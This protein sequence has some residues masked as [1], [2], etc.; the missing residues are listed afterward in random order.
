[1]KKIAIIMIALVALSSFAVRDCVEVRAAARTHKVVQTAKKRAKTRKRINKKLVRK[2]LIAYGKR[3][4]MTFDSKLTIKTSSWFPPT[5]IKYYRNINICRKGRHQ[6][7]AGELQRL[8]AEQYYVQCQTNRQISLYSIQLKRF[9]SVAKHNSG[10]D[11][12]THVTA[13]SFSVLVLCCC[14]Y[15]YKSLEEQSPLN[16]TPIRSII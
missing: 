11:Y 9:T 14:V 5:N 4:G 15:F 2:R 8:R 7:S 3:K 13:S 1:M 12:D 16:W 10:R 6:I